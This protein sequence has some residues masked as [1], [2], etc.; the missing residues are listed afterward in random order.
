MRLVDSPMLS[1]NTIVDR[2]IVREA[3]LHRFESTISVVAPRRDDLRTRLK[4]PLRRMLDETARDRRRTLLVAI[5]RLFTRDDVEIFRQALKHFRLFTFTKAD[6]EKKAKGSVFRDS[7]T[8]SNAF[9]N[10]R[11]RATRYQVEING[12]TYSLLQQVKGSRVRYQL[13]LIGLA[14]SLSASANIA[15]EDILEDVAYAVTADR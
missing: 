15:E 14:R 2:E 13:G 1:D 12:T 11:K 9:D 10:A 6:L 4:R 3:T 7:A 5:L 8:F